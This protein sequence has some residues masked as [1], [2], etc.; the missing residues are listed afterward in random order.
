M[1]IYG[2][3]GIDIKGHEGVEL[4]VAKDKTTVDEKHKSSSIGVSV[5][6]A[7]S[8]K[9]TIDNVKDIDKLTDFGGNSYDI[10]NTASDL[11]GAIKEGAEAIN[12][13]KPKVVD[14]NG[15][16]A[17]ENLEGI[18]STD[19]N[20]YIT[21]S[22]GVNKSKSEYHSSSESTVKN[23][24]ESKGDI[25]ISSGAGSVI[26]E[27][28]DIK[29]E[30]DLNL[31]AS[32]DVVVKSSKDEYSSSSSSSSKGLNADLTVSTNPKDMLGSVIASQS[33]GKGNSEGTVNVNSKFEVGGTHKVEAGEKVIYEGANV[34]AGRVEIKGEEV[35]IASSKDTE[36][37]SSKNSNSSI[38][39]TP[40]APGFSA[41]VNVGHREGNGEKEWVSD[42]TSIIAKE[43]GIIE[44][45][46][47]TN[48]GAIIG[49][50]SEENKLIVKAENITVEHLKDKDTNKVSG[51][52]I[53]VTGT[54]VPN[55]SVVTGGQDKR[56]DTNATAVNTEFEIAGESKTAEELGFNTDLEKAQVITKDEDKVLDAE[57]HTD[58][59]NQSERD[60]IAEAG[61]YL[62]SIY[63]GI[64]DS[65]VGGKINTIK[66]QIYGDMLKK[67]AENY[68]GFVKFDE[69]VI[70]E[71]G[72]IL[73]DKLNEKGNRVQDLLKYF[74]SSVGYEGEIPRILIG[75]LSPGEEAFASTSDNTIAIDRNILASADS[76]KILSILA[77]ELGHFNGYDS[78]TE[79]TASRIE[80]AV[81][82]VV[83]K[84]ES[85][86]DYEAYFKN[87]YEGK[88]IS[89]NEAQKIIDGISEENRE[90][91]T[92]GVSI[93]A[94]AG[95]GGQVGVG[96]T[97]Y[98]TIDHK[99]NKAIVFI[100]ADGAVDF[101]NPDAG[102]ALTF[103]FYPFV[104]DPEVLAGR[105]KAIGGTGPIPRL[106]E[107][108]G[109]AKIVLDTEGKFLGV[110]FI[111][112]KSLSPVDVFGGFTYGSKI[113]YKKEY[114]IYEYYKETSPRGGKNKW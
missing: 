100:T 21:V 16:I 45:K 57:L 7:G 34:E 19:V 76:N 88:D 83:S 69:K 107:L 52:G 3:T 92:R 39:V 48:S 37:S 114:T 30:K 10:A 70:D 78:G 72:E 87:M 80:N 109:G 71:N 20:S 46:D 73:T 1:D 25:N 82:G 94:A 22:A 49:S 4:I 13:V 53:E 5:G 90:N 58:L 27:G 50:E 2:E 29:T 18:V 97:K 9:T 106:E 75:D 14:S 44:S 43:G 98:T 74:A 93:G 91:F 15:N 112:G 68:P 105:A 8:I 31:S 47:F 11:V 95:F 59:L 6:V 104:N 62:E 23:K 54:G 36:K 51:G 113:I 111:I 17:S 12:K 102:A 103:S 81:S 99:N 65:G 77:H 84:K 86:G 41:E 35:I 28:T 56:Q 63:K 32:K 26:I 24:L 64:T 101:A 67:A 60:K 61:D 85:T 108:S 96:L 40:G 55:L 79:S 33:K 110:G 66:E 42:Q 89:G 38:K